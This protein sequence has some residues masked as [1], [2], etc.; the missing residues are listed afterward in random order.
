MRLLI[1]DI[2]I[3]WQSWPSIFSPTRRQTDTASL[4][5][6]FPALADRAG[7]ARVALRW[8]KARILVDGCPPAD[9]A[10]IARSLAPPAVT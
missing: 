1:Y 2:S 7:E 5:V 3:R 8:L 10:L 6:V 4:R 9:L